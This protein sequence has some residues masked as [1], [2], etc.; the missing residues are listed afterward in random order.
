MTIPKENEIVAFVAYASCDVLA[1]LAVGA[2]VAMILVWADALGV[3][4]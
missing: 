4:L 1:L 2:F 3:G